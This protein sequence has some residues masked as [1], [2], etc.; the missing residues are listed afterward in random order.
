ML[1]VCDCV[2]A[3]F[4]RKSLKLGEN[5]ANAAAGRDLGHIAKKQVEARVLHCIVANHLQTLVIS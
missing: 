2:C 1:S 4:D 3:F 5:T